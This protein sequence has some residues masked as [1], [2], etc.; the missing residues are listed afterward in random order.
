MV[1]DE[2][3]GSGRFSN[4]GSSTGSGDNQERSAD[5]DNQSLS[6]VGPRKS[7]S[8][9]RVKRNLR[10]LNAATITQ[11][12]KDL[13]K[14]KSKQPEHDWDRIIDWT[15]TEFFEEVCDVAGMEDVDEVRRSFKEIRDMPLRIR[16][17]LITKRRRDASV[18]Q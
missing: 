13:C 15:N 8:G 5:Q 4:N 9:D 7:E 6:S 12:Y 17:E 3:A 16:K 10:R 1:R 2:K 18:Y 14:V 11:A